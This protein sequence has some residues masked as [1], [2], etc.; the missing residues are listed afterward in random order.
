MIP[1][2]AIVG[3]RCFFPCLNHPLQPSG[4]EKLSN[5]AHGFWKRIG[6][7]PNCGLWISIRCFLRAI[8]PV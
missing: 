4:L 7:K 8:V 3:T 2:Q 6:H 1:E 5:L